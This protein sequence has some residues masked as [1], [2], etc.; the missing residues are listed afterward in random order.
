[1][2]GEVG[3]AANHAMVMRH[4]IGGPLYLGVVVG[5]RAEF[6]KGPAGAIERLRPLLP[7]PGP[8]GAECHLHPAVGDD[9]PIPRGLDGQEDHARELLHDLGLHAVGLR[10]GHAREGLHAQRH[11]AE[12]M[13][14]VID[15]LGDLQ[16]AL[17]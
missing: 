1:M 13:L 3:G 4:R 16:V 15:V 9:L 6:F 17:A 5:K 2:Q 11:V 14:V 10:R 7:C 12:V 8:R